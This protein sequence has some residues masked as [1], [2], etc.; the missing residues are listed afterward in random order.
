MGSRSSPTFACIF[1][2]MLELLMLFEWQRIGEMEPHLWRRFI[3]D[4]FFIWKGSEEDLIWFITKLN[5]IHSTIKFEFKAG[6]SFNFE[7]QSVNFLNLTICIDGNGFIKTTL[8]Q[9]SC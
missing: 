8:F 4:I 3:D 9:K 7:T 1:M 2:G 5:S 6:E